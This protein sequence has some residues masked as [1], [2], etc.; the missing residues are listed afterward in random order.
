[1]GPE[2]STEGKGD[3]SKQAAWGLVGRGGDGAPG[4]DQSKHVCR[5]GEGAGG[6]GDCKNVS[7]GELPLYSTT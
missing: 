4:M 7:Q 1:M 6:G 3:T 2:R 5:A